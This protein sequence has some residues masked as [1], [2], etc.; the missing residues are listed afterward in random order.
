MKTLGNSATARHGDGIAIYG[1]DSAWPDALRRTWG[2]LV[3][4]V[5]DSV[6]S[7][8]LLGRADPV[9]PAPG[10]RL[11]LHTLQDPVAARAIARLARRH[12]A[13]EAEVAMLWAQAPAQTERS[14]VR[15]I[16]R[17]LEVVRALE[18]RIATEWTRL[19]GA[20]SR[21]LP[22]AARLAIRTNLVDAIRL[23]RNDQLPVEGRT[24]AWLRSDEARALLE[25]VLPAAPRL[26][27]R[28]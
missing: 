27:R 22:A 4:A 24:R 19:T 13:D 26:T 25:R 23:L 6:G 11:L 17:D 12:G 21:R 20:S 14:R 18:S 10:D 2:R 16:R 9:R 28:R 5:T 15:R 3:D 8:A 7:K 1:P